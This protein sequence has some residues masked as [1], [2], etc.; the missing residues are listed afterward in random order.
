MIVELFPFDLLTA[1]DAMLVSTAGLWESLPRLSQGGDIPVARLMLAADTLNADDVMR[2]FTKKATPESNMPEG[3][4][5]YRIEYENYLARMVQEIR[6][7]RA[8]LM[9]NARI[10]MDGFLGLL[11]AYGL[12]AM[13][14][15]Q[16]MHRPFNSAL[17]YWEY[18][19]TDRGY[20]GLLMS[21]DDQGQAIIHPRL[22]HNLLSQDFPVY[23]SLNAY[24]YPQSESMR[25]L[26]QKS[27]LA[28]FGGNKT[29]DA[30]QESQSTRAGIEAISASLSAGDALHT[31]RVHVLVSGATQREMDNRLEIVQGALPL[32]MERVFAPNVI[33]PKLFSAEPLPD[34]DGTPVTT[35]G[36][37]LLA[38]SAL[39]YRRRT[40]TRGIMLGVDRNQ[41]PVIVDFFDERNPSYNSVILGQTG[42]GKTF[43]TLLLMMRHLLMGSRLII[44]DP[45]GN[46]N[47]DFLGDAYQRSVVGTKAASV[48]VLDFVYDELDAQIEMAIAMLRL[49]G[50]HSDK[51]LERALLDEAFMSLY[52]PLWGKP[53][54]QAPLMKD[55]YNWMVKRAGRAEPS[56]RSVADEL[57]MALQTYVTGSRAEQFGKPTSMDFSLSHAVTV[58]DVS[59]LPQQGAGGNLRSALLSI[60]VA[61]INQG[62]RRRRYAG[63]RAPILFFVDEMGILMRDSVVAS[64]ISAEYKTS[65]ARLVG[66]IV[67]DQDLHSLLGPKD[68]K[69]L[70]HGIPILANSANTFIFNQKDS[71]LSMIR[72]HF[73]MLPESIVSALPVLPRGTC[74]A[75][76][77]DGDLLMASVV[78]SRLDQVVLS[79]RL[80]DR[81]LAAKLVAK[82]REEI[83]G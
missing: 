16:E 50:V 39:S 9:L 73:P 19:H 76:F 74:A 48:N 35:S 20:F 23:V 40:E 75:Q 68:D 27:A 4:L 42:S 51:I 47:L 61:N 79:S 72:E 1:P 69:G 18:L 29:V 12:R 53:E 6:Y 55:L 56:V 31:F 13:P 30:I 36:I 52:A 17:G 81:E 57:S 45:Q 41:A 67:A 11:G 3:V 64:Y 82:I 63:D 22:F 34:T 25:L 77:A 28:S 44:L 43:A 7:V 2:N 8:Y 65:R 83:Y 80:Q 37:A 32:R 54:A 5:A 78:P 33:V 10:E 49:L 59:R 62:I 70:H 38:G 58:F 14:I 66:M 46:I 21:S 15:S 71:E 60:L 24:T 26:N